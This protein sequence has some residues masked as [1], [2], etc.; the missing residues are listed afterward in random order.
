MTRYRGKDSY[1]S[2]RYERTTCAQIAPSRDFQPRENYTCSVTPRK[3]PPGEWACIPSGTAAMNRRKRSESS[4]FH[5]ALRAS[6][7]RSR[8][9]AYAS[10]G[11]RGTERGDPSRGLTCGKRRLSP[12]F[13]VHCGK[14]HRRF[15]RC[16]DEQ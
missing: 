10:H 12:R 5:A 2:R 1:L 7:G 9:V 13:V 11:P 15:S 3:I 16:L 8:R 6:E 14:G 4:A